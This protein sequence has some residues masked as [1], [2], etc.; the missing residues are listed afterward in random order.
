MLQRPATKGQ[1]LFPREGQVSSTKG[2]R[3]MFPK[4]E[5]KKGWGG[6]WGDVALLIKRKK[7]N[8]TGLKKI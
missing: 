2:D 1:F 7:N 5:C 6:K 8:N 3:A 4:Q